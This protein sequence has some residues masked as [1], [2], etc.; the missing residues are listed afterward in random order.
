M[1]HITQEELFMMKKMFALLMVFC[2]L[3]GMATAQNASSGIVLATTTSTQQT[4]LLD[5]LLPAFTKATGIE[6]KAVAVGTGKAIELGKNGDADVVMVHARN[7]EDAFVSEGYGVEAWDLMFNDFVL[8][9]PVSDPEQVKNAST[10]AEA[11]QKVAA[12]KTRFVSRGDKSGTHEKELALWALA[13]QKPTGEAYVEAGQGMS[14]TLSM[15]AEMQ[16]Y[17]LCDRATWLFMQKKIPAL[18]IQYE[19]PAE[20]NNPYGVIA[21]SNAKV[22]KV[23]TD[24]AKKFV[25]WVVA[26][27]SQKIIADYKVEGQTLFHLSVKKR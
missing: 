3:S 27:E 6:V 18:G 11:F 1:P 8:L 25:E 13:K 17:V 4:G 2:C 21:V 7:L 24:L 12:G 9:G 23:K 14:E 26:A 10:A 19:N 22:A 20:L 15:A 5:V 16:A